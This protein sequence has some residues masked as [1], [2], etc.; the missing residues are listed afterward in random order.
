MGAG[1]SSWKFA[2]LFNQPPFAVSTMA[3]EHVANGV[4]VSGRQLM[5]RPV[6][7]TVARG[8]RLRSDAAGVRVDASFAASQ[9]FDEAHG[10]RLK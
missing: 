2:F 1:K 5:A 9:L 4:G 8:G 10:W 7:L 6:P 3:F